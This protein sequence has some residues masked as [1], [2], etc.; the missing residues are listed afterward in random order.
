M[1]IR[2]EHTLANGYSRFDATSAE[3]TLQELE[4]QFEA[5]ELSRHAY[6]EK[7]RALVRLFV[8]ST[9]TPHRRR[10]DTDYDSEQ[11]GR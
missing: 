8:K 11:K 2:E 6:F 4:A 1:G 7:K 5:G 9:T 3:E 10:R